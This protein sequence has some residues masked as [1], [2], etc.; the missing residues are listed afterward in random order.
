MRS[1]THDLHSLQAGARRPGQVRFGTGGKQRA[2]S[3]LSRRG[4]EWRALTRLLRR[5]LALLSEGFRFRATI[6]L[7]F[8]LMIVSALIYATRHRA[9]MRSYQATIGE[10]HSQLEKATVADLANIP[11]PAVKRPWRLAFLVDGGQSRGPNVF[12]LPL[13]PLLEPELESRHGVN[14]RLSPSEP[15]DWLFL[16]RVVFS[17]AAFVLSYDAL[18]GQRQRTMLRMVLSYPV[19]RWHVVAAKT[20]AVWIALATPFVIGAPWCLLILRAYGG[21]TFSV[22][23]W[24]KI[25]SVSLLALWALAIFVL[26]GLLVSARS[27]ESARSLAT[28]ALLW[29]TLVVVLP[30]A[31]DLL[32]EATHPLPPGFETDES[33]D[34]IEQQILRDGA[35][36]LR[37]K[38]EALADNFELERRAAQSLQ[39][40]RADQDKFRHDL[41][42][43]RFQQ[44]EL[45]RRWASISPTSLVQDVAE[46]VAGSGRFRDRAFFDQ[47]WEHKEQIAAEVKA[48]DQDDPKSPH[49]LFIRSLMSKDEVE[50]GAVSLFKLQEVGLHAGLRG[51]AREIA[52]LTLV[53]LVLALV[54]LASFARED[55]G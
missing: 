55:V 43:R 36:T 2:L 53:T 7:V 20:A 23:E 29:V 3:R 10:Y 48:L 45:A 52:L 34:E 1:M 46:R 49:V 19:A 27:R 21:I 13:S 41:I 37:P 24:L 8:G 54:V 38:E 22:T 5:E 28:L 6:G 35:V 18:C 31:G 14:R 47:A 44:Q 4:D 39:K 9:E 26:I 33:I 16:I 11:H 12:R 50:K 17:L 51:A 15:L 40:I 32:V 30:A 25:L 42:E